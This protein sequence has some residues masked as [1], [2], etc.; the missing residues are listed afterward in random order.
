V[1]GPIGYEQL[2]A[3]TVLQ[4]AK[5]M[6]AAA[7]TAPKSGGQLL[8]AGKRNFLETVIISDPDTR[9]QMANWLRARGKERREAIW[10][11]DAEVAQAVDAVLLVGLLAPIE[12]GLL[13]RRTECSSG[14]VLRADQRQ[15]GVDTRDVIRIAGDH[16]VATVSGAQ[17]DVHV[18]D[19]GVTCR[20]ADGADNS[21]HAQS[22][23]RNVDVGRL[24]QPGQ[25]N[26]PRSAPGLRGDSDRD[27]D[28]R[29]APPR[30]GQPGLHDDGLAWVIKGQEGSG[31]ESE[32]NRRRRAHPAIRERRLA[33]AARPTSANSA[34][35]CACTSL[36]TGVS[37]R[38]WARSSSRLS[39]CW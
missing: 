8:L 30:L 28:R 20:G 14:A 5:L 19:I 22:H 36:G 18:D 38:H 9:A 32:S 10:F 15:R 2:R 37:A 35:T 21:G 11:R 17:R 6:A 31:V 4:V 12:Y 26:L 7:I 34:S 39:C 24:D 16:R 1:S 33:G 13:R 23:D 25:A 29:A 3:D 27:A